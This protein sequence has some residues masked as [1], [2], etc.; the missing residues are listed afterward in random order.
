MPYSPTK[1]MDEKLNNLFNRIE[2]E[3]YKPVADLKLTAWKTNEPVPFKDRING[4]KA[5]LNI[6]DKWGDLF[7]CAW[8]YMFGNIPQ[9][10]ANK[11]IVLL[12]D[13]SGEAC[14]VDN[15][16][17]PIQGL[18]TYSSLYDFSLGTPGKKIIPIAGKAQPGAEI[19][20]WLD[21][22]NNDLF[23]NLKNNGTVR[24]ACIAV[25]N[26]E[27][28][29]LYYDF[30]VLYELSQQL[31]K[32]TARYEQ[33]RYALYRVSVVLNELTPEEI[34]EA[35]E[36]LAPE[37]ARK[38]GDSSLSVSAMGHAHIDL[39]WLWPIRETIRKGARTFS[40]VLMVMDKYP[41]FKFG[42]SQP[43]LYQ[44][45]KEHY[46]V[47]Y[48]RIK[49]K[50]KQNRWEVF[51]G[52]WV[53]ID[54]NLP[55]S[56]ALVRQ[57]LYARQF[58]KE[59]FD[60]EIDY[61]FL[62]DTFGYTGALPQIMK[63]SGINYFITI[64]LSWDELNTYP[65][66]TFIWK[67][68]DGS[69]V[70]VHMPPEGTYNS[71][72]APRAIK[73][74]EADYLDKAVS[75]NCL[76]LYGI[77][78]GGGGPGYEHLERLKREKNLAGIAPVRQEFISTFL[79]RLEKDR[80]K[81]HTWNGELYLGRHQG[82]LTSQ[83]LIKKYNR[84]MEL[85]L[86]DLE[87]TSVLASVFTGKKYPAEQIETIWKQVL[88]YQFHDII[89][90]DSITRVF[91]EA[92]KH[93]PVLLKETNDLDESAQNAVL[94]Q[95]NTSGFIKPVVVFNSLCWQRK[96]WLKIDEKWHFVQIPPLGY[97]VI[98]GD[99]AESSFPELNVNENLLEN[100]ILR[101]EFSSEGTI[102]SIFDKEHQKQVLSP[103]TEANLLT[104]YHDDGDAFDMSLDYHQQIA[105]YFKLESS[106][107]V[108]DGPKCIVKQVRN[109]GQ[110]KLYQFISLTAGSR[111]IDFETRVDWKES[112]KMLRAS[113][114]VDVYAREAF[115]EIQFGH[116][117]RP[118]H[119]NTNWDIAQYE[120]V[121]HRWADLSDRTYGVALLNDCKY[122]YKV[123]E[124]VLDINLLRCTHWP[125][126]HSDVGDH[127]F[128]YALYPHA[129][130]HISAN[131][132]QLGYELNIPLQT[133]ACNSQT[134]KLDQQ[135][136]FVE[137]DAEN[138]IIESIKKAQDN[139]DII[140][141][142]YEAD[143]ISSDCNIQFNL[144]VNDIHLTNL[145]EEKI[146]HLNVIDQKVTLDFKAFEIHTIRLIL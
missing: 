117:K 30:Q 43:Q 78:D 60:A 58:F 51:G 118:T 80:H 90:G 16:G 8:F 129:G 119:S 40:N 67:G 19:K 132:I 130:D 81:L 135:F 31:E 122:G 69:D 145:M 136:S 6:G 88:L 125:A 70:L 92:Y 127:D 91:E 74:A 123:K 1:L 105:G 49:A 83:G 86:R 37:L 79:Q 10:A 65:H 115:F 11:K 121:A 71:S 27:L 82:T 94:R 143:G 54:T 134:G 84:S 41:D 4:E 14:V 21:A 76:M 35:R 34:K 99:K 33:I 15:D 107:Y 23:G 62:P 112:N 17:N 85:A 100:E 77:G 139:E 57:F 63:K 146:K 116:I 2:D 5:E 101:I 110:S 61:L 28:R 72:A 68:I 59:E 103:K 12:V 20:I 24:Q 93:Y 120:V 124:N 137:I 55:G 18:T 3:I 128:L 46:P 98:E 44:W 133:A 39:A 126:I 42:A 97:T 138:I 89:T 36:I 144:N 29:Q 113:F 106:E 9:S 7:D 109:F 50:I 22:G 48:E 140:I 102:V 66:H 87:F 52:T 114:P 38:N 56:E 32:T 25:C 96:E 75:E 13:L 26:E 111:R 95:I 141:R 108:L 47:L 73:K 142:L 104:V 53:E 64:K 45:M 131:V